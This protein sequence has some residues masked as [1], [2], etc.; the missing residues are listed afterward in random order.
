MLAGQGFF[1][2]ERHYEGALRVYEF[3]KNTR[4]HR[5]IRAVQA[6]LGYSKLLILDALLAFGNV[7]AS[8]FE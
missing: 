3:V 8:A 6:Q 2:L 1:A 7:T 4:S 5:S